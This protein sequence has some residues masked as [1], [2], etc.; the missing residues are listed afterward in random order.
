MT[1]LALELKTRKRW[2]VGIESGAWLGVI[3]TAFLG[4]ILLTLAVYKTSTIRSRQNYYLVS[5][6][7]TDILNAVSCM[8]VTLVVL[9][10]GDWPFDDLI[11]ELQ[12]SLISICSTVSMLTMGMI[13]FN[14]YMK[15]VKSAS[16]Y[17]KIFT[18]RNILLSIAISWISTAFLVF[19]TF[20]FRK[21]V[22]NFHPGKCLCWLKINLKDTISLYSQGLYWSWVSII[23]STIVFSYYKVF[24]KIRAHYAQVANSSLHNDNSAAFAE[25]VKIT[26]M[27]FVTILA[28]FMC[29]IPSVVIDSYEAL[30]GY[31]RLPRQ[32]YLLNIFTYT[33]SSAINPFIYGLM[34]RE[35]KEAYKK[36][37]CCKEN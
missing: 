34:K 20:S 32:V 16:L 2:L 22:F 13:A 37:L 14:R 35:F 29:W 26:S 21:T 25:E 7:A 12:G 23:F 30:G 9:S 31:F 15:I 11:C 27:L 33:S 8:P 19:V 1:T 28:F 24:K 5:L 3:L 4:N 36:V 10:K 18:R 17:H 6:A